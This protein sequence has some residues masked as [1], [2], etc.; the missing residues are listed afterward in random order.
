MSKKAWPELGL[1][2]RNPAKDKEGNILKDENGKTI[3]RVGFKLNDDVTV[4]YKGEPVALNKS[5]TGFV[6]TPIQEVEGLYNRGAIDDDKIEARREKAK[7]IYNW[8]RYKVQ[9]PPPRGE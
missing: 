3:Y 2:T 9:L 6:Q 1:I 8:L 7:E 4:L 5:R